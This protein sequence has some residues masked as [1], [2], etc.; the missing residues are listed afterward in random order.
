[1]HA[2]AYYRKLV[3]SYAPDWILT[4][5]LGAIFF[6]L[7][8]FDGYRRSFSLTDTSLMHTFAEHPRV[9]TWLLYTVS[10]AAPAVL[11]PI[12]NFFSVRTWWDFHVSLLGLFLSASLNGSITAIVKNTVGRPRPDLL[13]RC[14]PPAGAT[15]PQFGLSEWTICANPDTSMLRDGFRSF[16]SG[17]S[18]TSFAGL[19]FLAF[20]LAGKMH[21]FDKRGHAGKSWI[22]LAPFAGATLIAISRTMD[23]RHHW[24]DVFVGAIIGTATA[25]FVYRQYYPSLAS[26]QARKPYSPRIQRQ[27]SDLQ[28]PT[29]STSSNSENH[30]MAETTTTHPA[31]NV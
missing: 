27:D 17:H 8:K 23:Y 13:A 1:M 11:M 10:W 16:P 31:T 29:H 7:D 19:G 15:D 20:Y 21:L 22:A 2:Q 24:H 14:L 30:P 9:P 6:S 25:Y 5:V 18:S 4:F 3:I 26:P 28:L 12:A